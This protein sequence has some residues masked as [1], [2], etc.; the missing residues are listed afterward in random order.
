M[1]LKVLINVSGVQCSKS[2]KIENN[3]MHEILKRISEIVTK[4]A[5]VYEHQKM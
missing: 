3:C 2:Y 5:P 1:N 4:P